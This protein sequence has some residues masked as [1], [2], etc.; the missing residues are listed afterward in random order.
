M[1]VLV[2]IGAK[3]GCRAEE[4]IRSLLWRNEDDLIRRC[5]PTGL[6]IRT[7]GSE[8]SAGASG[9]GQTKQSGETG[10][11]GES[12]VDFSGFETT[13][14]VTRAELVTGGAYLVCVTAVACDR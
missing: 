13:P 14:P 9:I 11:V 10:V 4:G 2:A 7:I 5:T 3:P 8:K 6:L 1:A 12:A